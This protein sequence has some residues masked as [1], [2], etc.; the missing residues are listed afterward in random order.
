[1]NITKVPCLAIVIKV[2]GE[3]DLLGCI[4]QVIG[5]SDRPDCDWKVIVPRVHIDMY[6]K[7]YPAGTIG[8]TIDSNLKPV[9]GLDDPESNDIEITKPIDSVPA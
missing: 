7:F 4:L 2:S 3:C 6:G 1:M 5:K 9:S 8:Y